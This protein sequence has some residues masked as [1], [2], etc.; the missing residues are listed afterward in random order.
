MRGVRHKRGVMVKFTL[1]S[2]YS[3]R[4][5]F[6]RWISLTSQTIAA[7]TGWRCHAGIISTIWQEHSDSMNRIQTENRKQGLMGTRESVT[8]RHPSHFARNLA[9]M[10]TVT[11]CML[12]TQGPKVFARHS[13]SRRIELKNATKYFLPIIEVDLVLYSYNTSRCRTTLLIPFFYRLQDPTR[14]IWQKFPRCQISTR[15]SRDWF[16][17]LY[18]VVHVSGWT[19]RYALAGDWSTLKHTRWQSWQNGLLR[20]PKGDEHRKMRCWWGGGDDGGESSLAPPPYLSS[21]VIHK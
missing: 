18:V 21:F 1:I 7:V 9:K 15:V 16:L 4:Q 13:K 12:G 20:T 2:E 11:C 10:S 8:N 17:D 6:L 14:Y 19:L 3:N 5:S